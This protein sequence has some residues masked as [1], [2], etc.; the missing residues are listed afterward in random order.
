M[1]FCIAVFIFLLL[2]INISVASEHIYGGMPSTGSYIERNGYVIEFDHVRKT[3][4]W[5][6]YHVKPSYL[7]RPARS[8][9][10]WGKFRSDPGIDGEASVKEYKHQFN[11]WRNYAKGHLAPYFI[12]GGDRDNDGL[13]AVD[14]DPEDKKTVYEVMYMSNMAPQHHFNFNGAGGLWY[15]LET[16]AREV[17]LKALQKEIWVFAG[18]VYGPGVYDK[19]GADI[20][21]PPMFFKIIIT[22]EGGKPRILAFL[23]PHQIL[24]HG[25]I[26][27]YLVSVNIIEAMTGLNFFTELNDEEMERSS[28]FINWQKP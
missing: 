14:D 27:D 4:R 23:F 21:V 11:T 9:R 22:I 15:R 13:M 24:K 1:R 16:Y 2:S 8:K 6:A 18:T 28:T 17:L 3:P 12:C 7:D 5:V 10:S 25:K 20:E 19:I 26:Q